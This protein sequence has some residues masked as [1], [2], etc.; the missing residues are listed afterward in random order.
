MND[1]KNEINNLPCDPEGDDMEEEREHQ[2]DDEAGEQVRAIDFDT[3][4][5]NETEARSSAAG[6]QGLNFEWLDKKRDDDAVK[7]NTILVPKDYR[8]EFGSCE[9]LKNL[10]AAM[11]PLD[12]KIDVPLHFVSSCDGKTVSGNET[13]GRYI[14]EVFVSNNDKLMQAM[15]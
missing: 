4:T 15:L 14:Q 6:V 12:P 13:G 1:N 2:E 5:N 11:V 9:H 8:G 10:D 3:L 7:A